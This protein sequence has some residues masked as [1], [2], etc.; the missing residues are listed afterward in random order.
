MKKINKYILEKFK[1]SKDIKVSNDGEIFLSALQNCALK[2]NFPRQLYIYLKKWINDID[3]DSFKI[4]IRNYKYLELDI[5]LKFNNSKII[6]LQNKTFSKEF[7]DYFPDYDS[8]NN[9]Y[10]KYSGSNDESILLINDDK[11]AFYFNFYVSDKVKSGNPW[12]EML[13]IKNDN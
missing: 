12:F 3:F 4:F 1:I 5:D 9:T 2:S 7:E 8:S 10:T 6:D 13:I 11:S